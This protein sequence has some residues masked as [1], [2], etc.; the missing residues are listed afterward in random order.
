MERW[1]DA[2]RGQRLATGLV[3]LAAA[4]LPAVHVWWIWP[5]AGDLEQGRQVLAEMRVDSAAMRRA[6]PRLG[7]VQAEAAALEARLAAALPARRDAGDTASLLRRVELLASGSGLRIGA[8]SPQPVRVHESHSEWPTRLELA[9][10]F[11]GV[12]AFFERLAGCAADVAAGDIEIR[13]VESTDGGAVV[14]VA[15]TIA[16]LGLDL[17]AGGRGGLGMEAACPAEVRGGDAAGEA[18]AVPA[19]PFAHVLQA[20]RPPPDAERVPGLPGLRVSELTLQGLVRTVGGPLA[21]VAAPSG[22]TYL[23]RGGE[24]LFDG[25]VAVV[26]ADAVVFHEYVNGVARETLKSLAEAADRR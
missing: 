25:A 13:A 9:G 6:A 2:M 17:P 14:A 3:V 5:L 23:L 19:D 7:P 21:V 18:A 16:V 11:P 26:R 10:P 24:Q 4:W 22:E 12:V 15:C 20:P 1:L 8:F